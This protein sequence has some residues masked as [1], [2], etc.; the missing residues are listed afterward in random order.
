[1]SP[2]YFIPSPPVVQ[3]GFN[4]DTFIYI[5]LLTIFSPV[6]VWLE[7]YL[8][9]V[10]VQ[11]ALI[12]D[13][14]WVLRTLNLCYKT[15]Y[16]SDKESKVVLI[17]GGS[18]GL[19]F[20]I[21]QTLQN[22]R[23]I[24]KIQV[25]DLHP[26][27]QF[28]SMSKVEF[29]KFDFNQE[30]EELVSMLDLNSIDV[31]ICN[32]GIRQTNTISKLPVSKIKSIINVNWLNHLLLIQQYV[33]VENTKKHLVFIGSLLGFVGP[34]KLGVYAATKSAIL[35]IGDSLREELPSSTTV[36]VILPG[37]MNTQMFADVQVNEFL[38]PVIDA[39]LLSERICSIINDN[40]NGTF[41]YPTYGRFLPVYRVLPW[42]LQ[43]FCRWFSGMDNV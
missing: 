14:L 17:T 34:T 20:R 30:I 23:S 24:S 22:D 18:N 42:G 10:S 5:S 11:S 13:S 16:K 32:A 19:G 40:L 7:V 41:S 25:I 12:L 31:L 39:S 27:T 38:A 1:M 29:I 15:A 35:S 37:Q 33:R 2:K 36:S 26:H 43:K 28:S 21:V 9:I 6:F 8:G 4:I 3:L